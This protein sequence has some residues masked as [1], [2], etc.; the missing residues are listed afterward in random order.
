LC[1]KYHRL[2]IRLVPNE[3]QLNPNHSGLRDVYQHSKYQLNSRIISELH[4][5]M[6]LGAL[7]YY[8]SDC[9]SCYQGHSLL[10]L[11]LKE[12]SFD[13]DLSLPRR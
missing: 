12:K 5:Q 3:I 11:Q 1:S 4:R 9:S 7:H 13:G 8:W 6:E 2:P 10:D